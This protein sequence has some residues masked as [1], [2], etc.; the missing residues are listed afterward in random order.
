[1][2]PARDTARDA[3]TAESLQR[4]FPQDRFETRHIGPRDA[5]VAAMLATLSMSTLDQ[6]IDA[7]VPEAI[8]LR[9]MMQLPPALSER[10]ALAMAVQTAGQNQVWR[11]MIGQGYHD[12]VTPPV[13]LRNIL[14]N[15]GWYTQ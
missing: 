3:Q 14:E 2:N 10:D 1:M 15:P 9:R 5:D 6:L 13:I 8:R 11:S 7:C 12:C 4:L